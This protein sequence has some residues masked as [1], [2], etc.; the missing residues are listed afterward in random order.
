[1]HYIDVMTELSHRY[2]V[3]A[4]WDREAMVWC[5][6]SEDIPGLVCEADT[7][8]QL[9]ESVREVAPD[10]LVANGTELNALDTLP[11]HV[12]ADRLELISSAR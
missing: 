4:Q 1:M 12:M 11:I 3:R 6:S 2:I 10:L 9:I 7:L 8:E 5:A